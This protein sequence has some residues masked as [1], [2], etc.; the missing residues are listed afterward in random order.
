MCI[1]QNEQVFSPPTEGVVQAY[2]LFLA[3]QKGKLYPWAM[4]NLSQLCYFLSNKKFNS[5]ELYDKWLRDTSFTEE[6]IEEFFSGFPQNSWIED[7]NTNQIQVETRLYSGRKYQTGFHAIAN[8]EQALNIVRYYNK[9]KAK[10]TTG[11]TYVLHEVEL[12]QITCTG[13]Q[14]FRGILQYRDASERFADHVDCIVGRKLKIGKL[15]A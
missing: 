8:R 5:R 9:I 7:Q 3:D 2:K 13:Q 10:D 11:R 14:S 4:W 12:D 15:C 6:F 1:E